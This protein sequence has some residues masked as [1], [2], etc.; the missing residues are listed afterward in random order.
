MKEI[1]SC[2]FCNKP[3]KF[4]TTYD[5]LNYICC[6]STDKRHIVEI[7]PYKTEK[8]AIEMWNTRRDK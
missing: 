7:G 4:I 5:G 6:T 8:K 1:K 3:G 2:P